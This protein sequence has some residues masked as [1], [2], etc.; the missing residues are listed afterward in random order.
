MSAYNHPLPLRLPLL[1]HS[2]L[3][4]A[5]QSLDLPQCSHAW[6]P[7]SFT[8]HLRPALWHE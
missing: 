2:L 7:G 6:P 1:A 3:P 4:L 8:M 5:L